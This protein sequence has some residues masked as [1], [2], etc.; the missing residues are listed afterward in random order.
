MNIPAK[1]LH[2]GKLHTLGDEPRMNIFYDGE[3]VDV[4]YQLDDKKWKF[5]YFGRTLFG[6]EIR[7][8]FH[9]LEYAVQYVKDNL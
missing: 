9:S 1:G 2:F 4:L 3:L 8:R 6:G 5:F 7:L